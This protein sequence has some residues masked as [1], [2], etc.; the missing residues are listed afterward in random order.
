M[1][2]LEVRKI[3]LKEVEAYQRIGGY[4][5]G[6]WSD[7]IEE[8]TPEPDRLNRMLAVFA[9]GKMTAH[10]VNNE[11][12]QVVRGVWQPAS[13]IGGV[14]TLPEYRRQ[15]HVRKL[16]DATFALMREMGQTVSALYPFNQSFYAKF[17]YVRTN[18]ILSL[19][20]ECSAL[21]HLLPLVNQAGEEWHYERIPAVQSGKLLQ[22][23]AYQL[24]QMP[25]RSEYHGFMRDPAR[26]A[27]DWKDE[28]IVFVREIGTT[29][30]P[31]IVAAARYKLKGYGD[32]T[33]IIQ[34]AHWN[35]A[36]A[37]DR[38]LAFVALHSAGMPNVQTHVSPSVNFHSWLSDSS[39]SYEVK[40]SHIPLMVR[41]MDVV[42]VLSGVQVTSVGSGQQFKFSVEDGSCPWVGG[43][44][45]LTELGGVL[46]AQR[47]EGKATHGI[48]P[49]M[50]I[51]GITAL[52]YGTLPVR[53]IVYRGWIREANEEQ[54]IL[55]EGWFPAQPL[56]NLLDF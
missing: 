16:F 46:A 13:G 36:S 6:V 29:A 42:Q 33:T 34:E 52:V 51:E 23:F 21:N 12:E 49:T 17:G 7:E 15:G 31:P 44:F 41:V 3:H 25:G 18:A 56:F 32:G 2:N 50:T 24:A 43:T 30:S 9:D 39:K 8:W 45:A 38:L 40:M 48:I 27:E 55:L 14:A 35:D 26:K 37:R 4:S 53:E 47:I 20:L 19:Q 22:D 54:T 5:Y 1:T 28:Q 10:L 11:F